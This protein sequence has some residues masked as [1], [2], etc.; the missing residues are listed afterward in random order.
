VSHSHG[1]AYQGFGVRTSAALPTKFLKADCQLRR[2]CYNNY[3]TFKGSLLSPHL[4]TLQLILLAWKI[5]S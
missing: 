2:L 1:G 3:M 4:L 5:T